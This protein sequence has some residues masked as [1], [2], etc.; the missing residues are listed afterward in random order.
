MMLCF[1]VEANMTNF[2]HI[3]YASEGLSVPVLA[4]Y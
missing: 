1:F 3:K 4:A 2:E